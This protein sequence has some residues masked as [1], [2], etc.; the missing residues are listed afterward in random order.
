MFAGYQDLF[1]VDNNSLNKD[2]GDTNSGVTSEI[3]ANESDRLSMKFRATP[4][5]SERLSEAHAELFRKIASDFSVN[6]STSGR[7]S[8][9]GAL[10][11]TVIEQSFD[12]VGHF[13]KGNACEFFVRF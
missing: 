9:H 8:T 10:V 13:G 4:E 11:R 6:A 7:N 3:D 5:D 1:I 12:V 2:Q